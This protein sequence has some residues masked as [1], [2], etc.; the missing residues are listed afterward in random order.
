MPRDDSNKGG[1]KSPPKPVQL[2][3]PDYINPDELELPRSRRRNNKSLPMIDTE[4]APPPRGAS[5][6]VPPSQK[7]PPRPSKR[8]ASPPKSRR[9]VSRRSAPSFQLNPKVKLFS[10]LGIIGL[11]ALA[12]VII[13][14]TQ[15]F[16]DNAF[17]VYLDEQ[18]VGY[19]N[20]LPDM[21]SERFHDMAVGQ[22]EFNLG[23]VDVIVN[24][25]L[26]LRETRAAV[27][28]RMAL[29]EM[30][31]RLTT[32]QYGFTYEIAAINIFVNNN[33][34]ATMRS[35][36]DVQ[37]VEHQMQSNFAIDGLTVRAEFVEDWR[38]ETRF[39]DPTNFVFDTIQ[40]AVRRMDRQEGAIVSYTVQSGDTLGLIAQ[41]FGIL[42]DTIE[43]HNPGITRTTV[44]S[45][46][47]SLQ[48]YTTV[49]LLNVR[50]F[51]YTSQSQEI[52]MPV[53][54]IH[55]PHLAPA[56]VR[57]IQ[58]GR[59]GEE[60]AQT[61]ITRINWEEVDREVLD[62]IVISEPITHIVEMGS[63]PPQDENGDD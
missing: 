44:L 47:Q 38:L 26:T 10:I 27:Q 4:T 19:I 1:Y 50:S 16:T 20:I 48:V 43:M 13:L 45:I 55:N 62:S 40:D 15:I 7:K 18:H 60:H 53:Q 51:D 42:I 24:E 31:T 32:P 28:D 39:V 58:Q 22:L 30:L 59:P 61:R 56:E 54:Q 37:V 8:H 14:I 63:L 12:I 52:P 57:T 6:D 35:M 9:P 5:R 23:G 41:R 25:R 36:A 34:E 33:L 3:A 21:D 49:P 29:G 46:G 11:T 2:D 17:A